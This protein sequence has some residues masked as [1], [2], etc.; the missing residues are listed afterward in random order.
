LALIDSVNPSA[1]AVRLYLL[2]TGGRSGR[3]ARQRP[4]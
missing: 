2:L 4:V 1:I 3:G